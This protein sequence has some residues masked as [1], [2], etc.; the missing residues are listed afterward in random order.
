[1]AHIAPQPAMV[2]VAT[3]LARGVHTKEFN[4]PVQPLLTTRVLVGSIRTNKPER[5]SISTRSTRTADKL[6]DRPMLTRHDG[7]AA[8]R[9]GGCMSPSPVWLASI[10]K[11]SQ[12]S[13]STDRWTSIS[14]GLLARLL[15]HGVDAMPSYVHTFNAPGEDAMVSKAVLWCTKSSQRY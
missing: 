5:P 4:E 9:H 11:Q 14:A 6:H 1:M 7:M 3:R 13:S 2:A 12:C 15:H 10:W 8:W